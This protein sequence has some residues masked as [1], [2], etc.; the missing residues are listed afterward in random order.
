ME[1]Y[2]GMDVL[3]TTYKDWE[4]GR[5]RMYVLR[6]EGQCGVYTFSLH[7]MQG[8]QSSLKIRLIFKKAF[9]SCR[10]LKLMLEHILIQ[11]KYISL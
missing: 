6:T 2:P 1:F 4:I 11:T 7:Q 9:N 5:G 8:R 3:D 10:L